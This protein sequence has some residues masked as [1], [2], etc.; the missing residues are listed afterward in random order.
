MSK[1]FGIS[2]I[3][4]RVALRILETELMTGL[5]YCRAARVRRKMGGDYKANVEWARKAYDKAALMLDAV[6]VDFPRADETTS[7]LERLKFEVLA[8]ECS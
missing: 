4:D 5:S 6:G 2:I 3:D 1:A 8:L 7:N